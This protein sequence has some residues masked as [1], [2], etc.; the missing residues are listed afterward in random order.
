MLKFGQ[1][2]SLTCSPILEKMDT[3]SEDQFLLAN[4]KFI[5]E[6]TFKLIQ[7][8]QEGSGGAS[9][10]TRASRR[11]IIEQLKMLDETLDTYKEIYEKL[12]NRELKRQ[13]LSMQLQVKTR[14]NHLINVL[15]QHQDLTELSN[16]A[17]AAMNN[18]A[19]KAI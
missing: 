16:S 18:V 4:L 6:L 11:K 17:I 13:L 8:V 5:N 15:R 19:F 12:K 14:T 10:D 9:K 2:V 7:K 1:V 3:P